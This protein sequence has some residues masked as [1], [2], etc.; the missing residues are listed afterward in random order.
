MKNLT[1]I[2]LLFALSPLAAQI[3]FEPGYYISN[4][5]TKTVG[6]IENRDWRYNPSE[7]KFKTNESS[8]AITVGM[9][10]IQ[11]FGID[12]FSKY[13]KA[14]VDVDMSGDK[15]ST[16]SNKR[17]PE[18]VSKTTL[19]K[20]LVDGNFT[21]LLY[22]ES[23][24]QRFFL[25]DGANAIQPLVFKKYVEEAVKEGAQIKTNYEYLQV[26][27]RIACDGVSEDDL[28]QI[29]YE[30][31]DLSQFIVEANRCAGNEAT[32]LSTNNAN[33][34]AFRVVAGVYS[35]S[36]S[37]SIAGGSFDF[38]SKIVPSFGV[39]YEVAMPYGGGRWSLLLEPTIFSYSASADR[40]S[41]GF[42]GT[43]TQ[44]SELKY[45]SLD[46]AAGARFNYYL[47][48]DKKVF[49]N[50]LAV[51]YLSPGSSIDFE[52][53]QDVE[54]GKGL[55]IGIGGGIE[56][57]KLSGEIRYYTNR[58]LFG[59]FLGGTSDNP[60]IGLQIGYRISK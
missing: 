3:K 1:I 48:D 5:G 28:F 40:T 26:L 42:M 31:K 41:S 34:S 13:I 8:E 32:N 39:Q 18:F 51:Y 33:K 30:M 43:T 6:L 14:T 44:K 57:G 2:F 37:G 55:N 60:R 15:V 9:D 36:F 46:I 21:L 10:G 19:L 25:K 23:D 20:V 7:I 16:Y 54:L 11:E 4:D 47:A 38:G 52:T 53:S 45:T 50:L 17:K 12:Q 35:T 22:E 24:L 59:K 27:G 29:D 56:M 58:D 49:L